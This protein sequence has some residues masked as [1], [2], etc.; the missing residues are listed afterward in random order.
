[1]STLGST[2]LTLSDW[3]KRT[4]KDGKV[5]KI[6]EILNTTNAVL[7]DMAFVEGN[8]PTGHKTTIR[9]G[10]PGVTWRLLNYGV[11]PSKSRTVQVTD[12]CGMLEAYSEVD[13][14]LADLNGNTSEFRLSEDRAFLEAMNQEMA[15][16]LFYGNTSVDPEKF[17]GLAP[18]YNSLSA[19]NASNIIS[20]AGAASD[21]TSIWLVCWGDQTVHGIFPKGS[22]AGFSHEDLGQETLFDSATP[23]GRFEGYRSHYKWDTGL[24]LRDW[25]YVVRIANVKTST[26]V[27]NAA[28]GGDLVDLMS[29][30]MEVLPAVDM[31]RCV[32]Y[33]NRTIKSF[34][35]RQ[36]ANRVAANLTLDNVSG[37]T[38]MAFDGVPVKR[39]DALLNTEATVS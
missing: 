13:K 15:S 35:R 38:V 23:A 18:R 36:I 4:D 28:T 37:E 29:Q 1:M 19:E 20:G 5:S 26:L 39:C 11:Q 34:L 2:A 12:T 32:F 16:V 8:L 21:N 10:L 33:C 31:G 30:A 17:M 9:S 6:V 7:D 27:K 24:T 3:A 22:K 14:A 25:R